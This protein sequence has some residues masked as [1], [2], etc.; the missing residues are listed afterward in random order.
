MLKLKIPKIKS[1]QELAWRVTLLVFFTAFVV[2]FVLNMHSFSE[3]EKELGA[4]VNDVV[5]SPLVLREDLLE[6]AIAEI[7]NKQEIRK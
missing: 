3:M 2:I 4:E 5:F 1:G 6:R 7:E